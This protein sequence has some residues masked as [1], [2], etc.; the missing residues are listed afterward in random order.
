VSL[1]LL[2]LS[3]QLVNVLHVAKIAVLVVA[4]LVFALNARIMLSFCITDNA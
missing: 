4:L 1:G 3:N 2:K